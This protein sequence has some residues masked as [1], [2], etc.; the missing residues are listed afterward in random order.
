M[1]AREIPVAEGRFRARLATL[2]QEELLDQLARACAEHPETANRAEAILAERSP[3][4]DWARDG[5]LLNVDLLTGVVAC[6]GYKD[7]AAAA[8]CKTWK[9][10]WDDTREGRRAAL[11]VEA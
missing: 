6:L 11:R 9:G 7:D 5:V 8:V 2:P 1:T 4:P 3:L 10:A